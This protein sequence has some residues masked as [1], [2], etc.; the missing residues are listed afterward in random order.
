MTLFPPP[1][2]PRSV[3]RPVSNLGNTCYM[4]AVLQALAHA[5]ELCLALD[6]EPHRLTCPIAAEN[7]RNKANKQQQQQQR[8]NNSPAAAAASSLPTSIIPEALVEPAPATTTTTISSPP[9]TRTE[10]ES[11]MPPQPPRS[12]RQSSRRAGNTGT[13]TLGVESP[14]SDA[15]NATSSAAAAAAGN[16]SVAGGGGRR[17]PRTNNNIIS[18]SNTA[19]NTNAEAGSTTPSSNEGG[20]GDG[21]E[22]C[23]LC[24]IEN[25][26]LKVHDHHGKNTLPL[27]PPPQQ[28]HH[29]YTRRDNKPVAPTAFV[30]GF[31]DQVAPWFQLGVQEDSHEFLRL[32]IDAMQKSCQRA[33][34][35]QRLEASTVQDP[36]D[37]K[38]G[39]SPPQDHENKHDEPRRE[40]TEYP[41]SLFRGTV[42]S[43]VVCGSCQAISSTLD[44]IED[45]GLEVTLPST[46][47]SATTA[48]SSR[49][50]GNSTT[51]SRNTS[52]IPLSSALADVQ[53]AFQRFAQTEELD[54][55]YKCEKCGKVGRATKQSRLASIP[56]ILTLH[57][58]RFR[59]G[60]RSSTMAAT[61]SSSASNATTT[62]QATRRSGRSSE[63]SQL[64]GSNDFI[65]SGKSGSAKIE[66]HIKFDLIF[67]LKPYLTEELKAKHTN[68]FC[69][70]FAVIVHA[71]KSSHS[72]HYIAFVRDVSQNEWWKMD[73]SRVTAVTIGEVMQAEAYMLLYRAVQHP[74][75]VRLEELHKKKV[76]L[77]LQNTANIASAVKASASTINSVATGKAL[78]NDLS[79][80]K[81]PLDVF[82]KGA[83]DWSRKTN[84]PPHLLGLI[85]KV[86]GLIA[87][88]IQ[89]TEH[90]KTTMK[91]EAA[92]FSNNKSSSAL[93]GLLNKL[94]GEYGATE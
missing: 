86:T 64:L 13:T 88:D 54:T 55:S 7:K 26:I 53:T 3:A 14:N 21:Y 16:S 58:K 30:H 27:P 77:E 28:Q 1:S 32:L 79:E 34:E 76:L 52:P 24:E 25:H 18:S 46:F 20:G 9:T 90:F 72:G 31:I 81:R 75:A 83:E 66:G 49:H 82:W 74:V 78:A 15:A 69:R 35:Q 12:T 48:S 38:G 43:N 59:Y 51:N 84:F 85:Q 65:L 56:P 22:F 8:T 4:N 80:K 67:D 57:L 44:P 73:D 94:G 29:Q 47:S 23:A 41:F 71:G 37:A 11:T 10:E 63:V 2:H 17:S 19:T 5:P 61:M 87:D 70:L 6:C 50:G 39:P 45:V 42:E 40:D 92:V 62:N 93:D 89:I 33:R 68:M 36:Q 91:N 60:D